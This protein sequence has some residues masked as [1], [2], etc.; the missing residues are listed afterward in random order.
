[1][2]EKRPTTESLPAADKLID[3]LPLL[4]ALT[5]MLDNQAEAITAVRAALPAI[6]AATLAAKNRLAG[7]SIGRLIYAGAGTSARIGVQDG[8][9]LFPTFNWPNTRTAFMI[10][11]GIDALLT[12]AENAEDSKDEAINR[13]EQ[14]SVTS[15]DVLIGLA[16]S[17]GT[18]YT[19]QAVEMAKQA[20]ALTIGISNNPDTPLLT[21]SEYPITLATGAESLAG[22]TRLKA[23]TA[24]KICLNLISTMIMSQLGMVKQGM[25][26]NMVPRNE[27]LRLRSEQIAKSLES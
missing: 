16:A 15:D 21:A 6:E 23:G 10:A 27:K 2:N 5:V 3:Q 25:M 8:A 13:V 17:G 4:S 1:M 11:G 7:T 14:L 20:G 22:S 9:E 26:V 18:T 19:I 12:P 24:Q